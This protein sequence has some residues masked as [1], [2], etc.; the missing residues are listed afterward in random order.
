[1]QA[2]FVAAAAHDGLALAIHPC[3]TPGDGDTMFC[4]ATGWHPAPADLTLICVAAVTATA[5]ATLN[6]IRSATGLA[7]VPAVGQ[8]NPD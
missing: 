1:M 4:A 2:N 5:Q 8:L 7:G 3:H 6:A